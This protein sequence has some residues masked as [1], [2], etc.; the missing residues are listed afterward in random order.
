MSVQARKL[1]FHVCDQPSIQ[2]NFWTAID[3]LH[4]HNVV[5]HCNVETTCEDLY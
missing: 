3:T 1:G 5:E 2:D 4:D